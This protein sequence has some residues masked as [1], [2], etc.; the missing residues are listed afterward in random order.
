VYVMTTSAI[1]AGA[2]LLAGP[3]LLDGIGQSVGI[4]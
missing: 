1:P 2:Q 3:S 4:R